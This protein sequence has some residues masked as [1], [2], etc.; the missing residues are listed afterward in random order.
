MRKK[1]E[2]QLQ[3]DPENDYIKTI[4]TS[5]YDTDNVKQLKYRKLTKRDHL[6]RIKTQTSTNE[7]N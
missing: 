3:F 5:R 7:I 2:G 4:Q 1:R 6:G